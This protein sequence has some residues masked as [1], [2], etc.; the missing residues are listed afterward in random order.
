MI[1][2]YEIITFIVYSENFYILIIN[3][4]V[5]NYLESTLGLGKTSC[6][7]TMATARLPTLPK[8][9]AFLTIIR[10][11]APAAASSIT[12]G[13][14]TWICSFRTISV[15]LLKMRPCPATTPIAIGR[16]FP[17]NAGHA[18]CRPEGTLFIE[19]TGMGRSPMFRKSPE[20]TRLRRA[21]E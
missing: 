6:T 14:A 18:A 12:T 16:E 3:Y 2:I 15:S 20:L 21:M 1:D 10:V 8:P 13:T 5:M 17:S 4:C 11:G 7:A 9:P 19:T